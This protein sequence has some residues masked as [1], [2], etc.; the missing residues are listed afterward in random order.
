[1]AKLVGVSGGDV[2]LRKHDAHNASENILSE[3]K[4]RWY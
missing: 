4:K 1:M 3:G 2:V